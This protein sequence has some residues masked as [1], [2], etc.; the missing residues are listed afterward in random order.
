MST[1]PVI[2]KWPT[3]EVAAPA[4]VQEAPVKKTREAGTYSMTDQAVVEYQKRHGS[5]ASRTLAALSERSNF[6]YKSDMGVGELHEATGLSRR[7]IEKAVLELAA[8]GLAAKTDGRWRYAKPDI[9][10]NERSYAPAP[11]CEPAFVPMRTTVRIDANERSYENPEITVSDNEKPPLKEVEGSKKENNNNSEAIRNPNYADAL[12]AVDGAGLLGVW[13]N[14]VVLGKLTKPT[15]EAQLPV[16]AEW[17]TAG[18]A[19]A[20]RAEAQNI[21]DMG[22]YAHPFAG[23]KKRMANSAI[24][25][26][27][28]GSEK[29]SAAARAAFRTGQRVRYPDGTEATVLAVLS[30]GIATDHPETPDVPLGM[31]KTLEVLA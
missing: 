18:R 19:D 17:I 1:A 2:I 14:W 4:V 9:N 8:L 16:W 23:L 29:G 3:P 5:A 11:E 27:A 15:Q 13:R 25:E 12:R 26:K 24:D 21:I 10:A 6:K 31:L 7:A 28:H 22:S 20:L 30:R